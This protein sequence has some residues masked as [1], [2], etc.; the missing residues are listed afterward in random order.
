[1]KMHFLPKDYFSSFLDLI[2]NLSHYIRKTIFSKYQHSFIH[3][4]YAQMHKNHELIKMDV[5]IEYVIGDIDEASE[6]AK[7][8]VEGLC[9]CNLLYLVGEC[10]LPIPISSI[11]LE[12]GH[13]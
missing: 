10:M 2:F 7:D 5:T 12:L 4:V 6:S 11:G 9:K 3:L 13:T 1:M 8:F